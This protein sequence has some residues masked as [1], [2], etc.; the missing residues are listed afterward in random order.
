[1]FKNQS[2]VPFFLGFRRSGN[3]RKKRRACSRLAR[4]RS[5]SL[6]ILPFFRFAGLKKSGYDAKVEKTETQTTSKAALSGRLTGIRHERKNIFVDF[7][8]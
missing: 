4:K 2:R 3:S 6:I 5:F 1:L 7:P 8:E